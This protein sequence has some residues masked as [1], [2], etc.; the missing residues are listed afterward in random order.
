MGEEFPSQICKKAAYDLSQ[1][2][3]RG[4]EIIKRRQNGIV[5][6]GDLYENQ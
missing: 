4:D 5:Y 1:A 6:I 2:S 3:T